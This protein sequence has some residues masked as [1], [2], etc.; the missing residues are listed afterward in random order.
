PAVRL[1]AGTLARC[2]AT[3]Q[4]GIDG[5]AV[6]IGGNVGTCFPGAAASSGLI[7]SDAVRRAVAQAAA[8]ARADAGDAATLTLLEPADLEKKHGA[9][10]YTFRTTHL[11]Q[12]RADNGPELLYRG[13]RLAVQ[14]DA[15]E[16]AELW[17]MADRLAGNLVNRLALSPRGG[18]LDLASGR[19]SEPTA[20][21]AA[22]AAHAL[23][24]YVNRREHSAHAAAAPVGALTQAA[25]K[26]A[27]EYQGVARE[28]AKHAERADRLAATAVLVRDRRS[29]AEPEVA[30][31]REFFDDGLKPKGDVP[32]GLRGLLIWGDGD[33]P[34]EA[35]SAAKDARPPDATSLHPAEKPV[36]DLLASTALSALPGEMP[37]LGWE[38]LEVDAWLN[39]PA[40]RKS[41]PILREMR[42]LIWRCQ[43]Q[44]V[45]AGPDRQD[46]IG[47]IAVPG[48]AGAAGEPSPTWQTA[49]LVAFLGTMLGEPEFTGAAERPAEV[50]RLLGAA[51]FL[52]Q[53]Q[54][55]DALGWMCKEPA[56]AKGALR[57]AVWDQRSKTD[58]TAMGLLAVLEVIGGL[59]RAA[60]QAP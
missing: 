53:L 60:A 56:Y 36:R 7:P 43:L 42:R 58:A 2:D 51:R 13:Q 44:D 6:V 3:L 35:G 49:R 26:S 52:R 10:L 25:S 8:A 33:W 45:D 9:V 32:P 22:L 17:H 48:G 38:E 12:W 46:M 28:I 23:D 50:V 18:D 54:V 15:D 1:T 40:G 59:E 47:G 21:A 30:A 4:P 39:R 29:K 11:A 20:F 19:A 34:R 24:A 37:W 55:D 27:D 5:V 16:V 14:Q 57:N 41:A 31:V